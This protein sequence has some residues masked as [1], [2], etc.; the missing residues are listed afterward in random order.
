M[1]ASVGDLVANLNANTTGFTKGL[2]KARGELSGFSSFAA[3]ALSGIAIGG[4]VGAV[5]A[6]ISGLKSLGTSAFGT[7]KEMVGLAATA[8][9]NQVAFST[10]LGSADKAKTV[11]A[12]ITDLAAKT[13]LETSELVS[14]G[15]SLIAFKHSAEEVVPTLRMLGD[16]SSGVQQ[17]IGE[18]A[19]I[20]GKARVQGR[21]FAEDI[22]QFTGR[23]IPIIQELA[24]QFGVGDEKVR[25]LVEDGKVGF[26]HLQKAF[27]ALTADGGKF[28]G[29][30]EAQSKT[31]AGLW[32]TA[33]DNVAIAMKGIGET[34]VE[35][36]GLKDLLADS[37]SFAET[38]QSEW[39]PAIQGTVQA[40]GEVFRGVVDGMKAAW[41]G[42]LGETFELL[43]FGVQN[44]DILFDI[45]L[46]HFI[47]FVHNIP[48]YFSTAMTNVVEILSW[49]GENWFDILK[50][51]LSVEETVLK[52]LASNAVG[53]FKEIFDYYYSLGDDPVEFQFKGL[54]EG[55]KNSIKELPKLTEANLATTTPR[56]ES[57]YSQLGSREAEAN[58]KAV[59]QAAGVAAPGELKV[60]DTFK[61]E[62]KKH[63]DT[64]AA[65]LQGS[66]EDLSA[67]AAAVNGTRGKNPLEKIG[68]QQLGELKAIH[69]E[70]A[71]VGKTPAVVRRGL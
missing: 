14:A 17:P 41:N 4:G 27:M 32:S 50:T 37:N 46:E 52:N 9:S 11:L 19:E 29:M 65:A 45:A 60:T 28:H 53:Y 54:T 1:A 26:P 22:N 66:K 44:W 15:R 40:A 69:T 61:T 42:W 34:I 48:E 21:L 68:N 43:K 33:K 49:M 70:I 58:K 67:V 7:A 31:L 12:Q 8:E 38:F 6:L 35:S 16:I 57:L 24:K 25:K 10:M 18:I 47:L 55:F 36:F 56:L 51:M 64:V 20:Y 62:G 30:M 59:A 63:K 5:T 2:T 13:P 39:L 71:K 23:G 3:S